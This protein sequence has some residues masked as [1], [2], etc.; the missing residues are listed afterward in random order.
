MSQVTTHILDITRGRPAAGVTITFYEKVGIEWMEIISGITNQ[1]GRISNLLD[2]DDQLP[3]GVYKMKF[4]TEEYFKIHGIE[5]FY[6]CVEIIFEVSTKE[7]YHIPLLLSPYGYS[8]YRG[9]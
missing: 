3:F 9:S 1:D 7:H 6:P 8:T 2:D 5:T 4:A